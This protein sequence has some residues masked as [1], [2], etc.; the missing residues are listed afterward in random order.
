MADTTKCEHCGGPVRVPV[1]KTIRRKEHVFCSEFCYHLWFYEI[2]LWR[3]EDV[4]GIGAILAG[5]MPSEMKM[6]IEFEGEIDL[7]QLAKEV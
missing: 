5:M 3:Y 1:T 4:L 2:D 7:K 6:K